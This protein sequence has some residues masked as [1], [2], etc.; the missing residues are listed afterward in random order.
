MPPNKALVLTAP[1]A[2]Q[3]SARAFGTDAA[4]PTGSMQPMDSALPHEATAP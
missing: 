2:R 4:L 3:H 1:A